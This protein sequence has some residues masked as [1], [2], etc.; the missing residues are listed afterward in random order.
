MNDM[1]RGNYQGKRLRKVIE[2]E[3]AVYTHVIYLTE[4]VGL[5]DPSELYRRI[6][7]FRSGWNTHYNANRRKIGKTI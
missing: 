4:K 6:C 3:K 7:S 2:R 5:K 1:T